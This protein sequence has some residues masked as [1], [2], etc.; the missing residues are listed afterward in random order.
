[1]KEEAH[2][3]EARRPLDESDLRRLEGGAYK[4]PAQRVDY[5]SGPKDDSDVG[6]WYI[7]WMIFV[8]IIWF[9]LLLGAF[10][11]NDPLWVIAWIMVG[12]VSGITPLSIKAR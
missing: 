9:I 2:L 4:P 8:K 1:M 12:I 11:S 5:N 10:L 6:R 3:Y 7:A